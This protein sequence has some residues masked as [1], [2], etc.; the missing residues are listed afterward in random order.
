M[1]TETLRPDAAGDETNLTIG[2]T[3]AASTNWESVDEV[4]ADENTTIVYTASTSYL[5]DLYNLPASSG[6]GTINFIKVYARC[7][8]YNFT[9]Y[10]KLSLKSN[11]TA[12]DGGEVELTSSY[13]TYSQQWNTNPAD[14]SAWEWAD[15]DALQIG[16]SLKAAGSSQSI[17]TQVYVEVDY[18]ATGTYTRTAA[19]TIGTSMSASRVTTWARASALTIGSAI[20]AIRSAMGDVTV[21]AEITIGTAVTA[22]KVAGTLRTAALSIGQVIAAPYYW[23]VGVVPLTLQYRTIALTTKVR[24]LALTLLRRK[25]E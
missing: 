22:T 14:S 4:T 19:L 9:S 24:S 15:I 16:V 11:S 3:G 12:T 20:T 1:A 2:G 6:S 23:G 21:L 7:Y 5:R 10:A 25:F 17:C 18:T 13:V 8:Y